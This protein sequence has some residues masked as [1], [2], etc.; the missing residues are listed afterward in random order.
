[1][2]KQR[3]HIFLKVDV[4]QFNKLDKEKIRKIGKT[5][6]YRIAGNGKKY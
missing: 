6:P 1:M 5:F 3:L 2:E 4:S